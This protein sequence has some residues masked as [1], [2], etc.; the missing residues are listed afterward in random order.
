MGQG[1]PIKPAAFPA[2][3]QSSNWAWRLGLLAVRLL[4][5]AVFL[6]SGTA[7]LLDPGQ[8]IRDIWAYRLVPEAWAWWLAAYL[9]FLEITAALGLLTSR[10]RRGAH[11]LLAVMLIVF[12]LA[13]GAAWARG[14]DISCGCFGNTGSGASSKPSYAWWILRDLLLL[15]GVALSAAFPAPAIRNRSERPRPI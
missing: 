14:L 7:K 1:T 11:L 12:V 13:L 9:P 6:W 3:G 2:S 5:A 10:Q 4:V 8:F 15:G